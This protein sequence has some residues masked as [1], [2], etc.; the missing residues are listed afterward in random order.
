MKKFPTIFLG[1][2]LLILMGCTIGSKK[3]IGTFECKDSR[4][5]I[6]GDIYGFRNPDYCDDEKYRYCIEIQKGDYLNISL[7]GK[8]EFNLKSKGTPKESL[9]KNNLK[10]KNTNKKEQSEDSNSK[11]KSKTKNSIVEDFGED[12]DF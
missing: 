8:C 5:T 11:P 4:N 6:Q 2:C 12:F 1:A 9:P 10:S 7:S 3:P